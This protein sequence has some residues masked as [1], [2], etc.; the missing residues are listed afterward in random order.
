MSTITR[1]EDWFAGRGWTPLA[2]QREAWSAYQQGRSGLLI[3]ATGTGKT[4]AAL[5]GPVLVHGD[6]AD[7]S[8]PLLWI[9]P[10]RALAAD[11][12]RNVRRTLQELGLAWT[13]ETRTG[14][15]ENRVRARQAKQWP[16]VL[17]TTPESLC[18]Q[19][20][21]PE[22]P[23]RLATL[24]GVVVDEWHELVGNK[25]GVLTQLALA[26]L[27]ALRP[28]ARVWGVS[29]TVR[30]PERAALALLGSDADPVVVRGPERRDLELVTIRPAS[31]ERFPWAG[32][33]GLRLLD[34]VI[35]EMELAA[36]SLLFTNTRAQSEQWYQA[37]LTARP[38][39]AGSIALHHGSLDREARRWVEQAL[40]TGAVRCVVCTSSLDL[41]VDFAPVD[42]VFQV[43]SPKG[44]ARLIQRAG[45][46]GHQPGRTPRIVCVPTHAFELIEFSAARS[47]IAAGDLEPCEPPVAP[48]DI[49]VQHL[50]TLAAGGG[51][52][53]E[54]AWREV[55]TAWS[56][57]SL[58]EADWKWAL[59]FITSG[60]AAL[61]AYEQFR[62]VD[63]VDGCYRVTKRRVA[64]WHRMHIGAIAADASVRVAYVRGGG[65]GAVEEA[66]AARLKK[67]DRFTLGGHIL[68]AV[69][70]VDATLFVRA[71]PN[72]AK[73]PLVPRWMGGRIPL[74]GALASRVRGRLE[75]A[76]RGGWV[77]EEMA[78]VRDVL[79]QQQ[80]LSQLPRPGE[81]LAETTA[82]RDGVHVFVY[83]FA[84]RAVH[85]GLAA[86]LAWR[87][88]RTRPIT[89]AIAAND[90][91]F[92]LLA[93]EDPAWTV[94]ALAAAWHEDDLERDIAACLHD[95][96]MIRRRFREIARIAGL[97]F[98][99]YPGARKSFKSVQISSGLLFDVFSRYEPGH[100]LLGQ[101]AREMREDIFEW[102][103]L[104]DALAMLRASRL[105]LV[106]TPVFSPL[107]FPLVVDR[108]RHRISS[109]SLEDRV[110]RLL[111]RM[112]RRQPDREGVAV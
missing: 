61:G 32:H 52:F 106:A 14:D 34:A 35:A 81:V 53:A 85:E 74:S 2:F 67:G 78:A 47:A 63:V 90:Y 41:G 97:I 4:L 59:A 87:I 92:E 5:L 107:A 49:L 62:K 8:H 60:G 71:A 110:R 65:I 105:R 19:F 11:L 40:D 26:R 37:L 33:L 64:Q 82:S 42:T 7:I 18:L 10:M 23:E 93:A 48:L 98:E 75:E 30:D 96:E 99:G 109:E 68:E 20:S 25:R 79:E 39:W 16:T 104:V 88:S 77:D 70:L 58:T 80:A 66:F 21:R 101:A 27:R 31:M 57:R 6:R 28:D 22:H 95:G 15:T 73:E 76:A 100:P 55:R 102:R 38:D 17:I 72:R 9:T 84:G 86:L 111:A 51:F 54:D 56:Y 69:R 29:A 45:R 1:V 44:V 36:T 108:M 91:G 103:R 94:E 112:M 89:F 50:V 3:S 43:G 24:Q 13:V 46:S 83:P 12:E